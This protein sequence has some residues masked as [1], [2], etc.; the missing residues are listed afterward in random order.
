MII[1]VA[2]AY[3]QTQGTGQGAFFDTE[4][5][6]PLVD[7]DAFGEALDI[8]AET[9][10]YGPPDEINLDVG[11]TRGLFTTGR[12]AL[13]IDW[14]DIGTLAIDPATSKVQDKVGAVILPGSS[15]VLD[16]ATGKLVDCDAT[17]CPYAIDGINHAPFAAF[18]GWS[19]AVNA[20]S[21]D[22]VKEAAYAFFSYMSRRSSRT[23][24]SRS[25]RPA[26]IPT[27][28]RSS[29]TSTCGSRPA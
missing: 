13:S 9:T 24:T 11:D 17:T 29:R 7:N 20:G 19:G 12:C 18:G 4:D 6:S 23:W 28:P 1:S 15:Q 8:Y 25:A 14:G 3:L 21:S 26:S 10:K 27:G 16:R 22:K 2:G 5:M